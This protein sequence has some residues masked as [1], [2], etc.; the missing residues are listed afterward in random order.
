MDIEFL[1]SPWF[2]LSV[3]LM[4]GGA[5]LLWVLGWAPAGWSS[6]VVGV[7]AMAFARYRQGPGAPRNH[8]GQG[9]KDGHAQ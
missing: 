8:P 5:F 7:A 4:A 1:R 6:I 2:M 9:P 3:I